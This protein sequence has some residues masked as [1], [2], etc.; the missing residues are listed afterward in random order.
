MYKD[1]PRNEITYSSKGRIKYVRNR[2][3]KPLP[4]SPATNLQE[5]RRLWVF[6][7]PV[8][9]GTST[10]TLQDLK[11]FLNTHQKIWLFLTSKTSYTG[12]YEHKCIAFQ[13]L[14]SQESEY[15]LAEFYEYHLLWEYYKLYANISMVQQGSKRYPVMD[16]GKTKGAPGIRYTLQLWDPNDRCAVRTYNEG[17]NTECQLHIWHEAVRRNVTKCKNTFKKHCPKRKHRVFYYKTCA[18]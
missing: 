5:A 7:L 15:T 16:V 1:D 3:K 6:I 13:V 17:G 9:V 14:D 8:I 10:P 4:V 18:G 11:D 12:K 2:S